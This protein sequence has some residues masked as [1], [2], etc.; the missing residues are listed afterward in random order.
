MDSG[1]A[2]GG[3][4]VPFAGMGAGQWMENWVWGACKTSESGSKESTVWATLSASRKLLERRA[5]PNPLTTLRSDTLSATLFP[6]E[7]PSLFHG[8]LP[9]AGC[10]WASGPQ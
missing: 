3:G 10:S 9:R 7:L 5:W 8:P 1:L 6:P 4:E 2:M